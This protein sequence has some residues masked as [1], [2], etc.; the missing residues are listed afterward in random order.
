MNTKKIISLIVALATFGSLVSAIPVFAQDNQP[1]THSGGYGKGMMNGKAPAVIGKVS[2][3]NGNSI[4]V[5][6]GQGFGGTATNT[7]FTVDATNAKITKNN[8]ASTLAGI[9]VGDT[10]V[11]QGTVSG[12]NVTA[13]AIRD[14]VMMG[15]GPKFPGGMGIVGTVSIIN[16]T[17]LTV[18]SKVKPNGGTATTYT[19]D[20]SNATVT[21]GGANSK[22]SSIAVGDTVMIQ[23]TING[24]NI[25]AKN[26]RDGVPQGQPEIQG[27]G[28]PVV[29][30][31]VTAINGNTITI[32]NK[33]SVTYAVDASKAKF[34]VNGVASPTIANV[35]VGDNLV[36]QGTVNGTAVTASSVIDQKPKTNNA[37][38][39][40]D[41]QKSHP[42]FMGGIMGGI[43][44]FFKHLFGF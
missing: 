10:I 42:G 32:T 40:G 8:T 41:N 39:T 24:T 15:G 19:I 35:A 26:I 28:Q 34:I 20:A 14:G 9:T 3:I 43:G 2:A 1:G 27:N 33:S 37:N 25:T 16:G 22:V 4:T 29:A 5:V 18:I 44:N 30:G 31:S 17:T 11:V 23:G 12:T 7:T 21:K 38:N 36:V 13:T 6:G